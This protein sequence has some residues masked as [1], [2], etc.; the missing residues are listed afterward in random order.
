MHHAGSSQL[1]SL[2]RNSKRAVGELIIIT[3][4]TY[5]SPSQ[6]AVRRRRQT[7]RPPRYEGVRRVKAAQASVRRLRGTE[8]APASERTPRKNG[9]ESC[10]ALKGCLRVGAKRGRRV[11]TP[12][13]PRFLKRRKKLWIR[14]RPH[15]L[16]FSCSQRVLTR[17][18]VSRGRFL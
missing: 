12:A 2:S 17:S 18:W 3:L 15:Q 4:R 9:A 7:L 1:F 8:L 16:I 6:G 5:C 11:F 10:S 14:A 13:V